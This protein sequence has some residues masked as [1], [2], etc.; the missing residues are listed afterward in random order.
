MITL[1][2]SQLDLLING[3]FKLNIDAQ[4]TALKTRLN[5]LLVT[6]NG[7]QFKWRRQYIQE[8]IN[9][10]DTLI[11]GKY[12]ELEKLIPVFDKIVHPTTIAHK[13]HKKFRDKLLKEMGYETNRG[14]FY[15]GF[16]KALGIKACVYCNSQLTVAVDAESYDKKK[17]LATAKI[18]AK[19]QI[20]HFTAKSEYPCFSVAY[21][22][23]YPVCGTCNN[24]KRTAS[25]KFRLFNEDDQVRNISA[26]SFAL[27]PGSE[28]NYL[29]NFDQA[30]IEFTFTDPEK[31]GVSYVPGSLTDTFDIVGIYETQKDV[32]EELIIKSQIYNDAYKQSLISKFPK[33]FNR[34][35]L[36][37]RVILGTYVDAEDIHKRPL[38]KFIQDIAKSLQ[39]I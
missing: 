28:A 14:E 10:S 26:Y 24:I 32:I 12:S 36:S 9:R 5:K 7:K 37:D 6:T 21:Y 3:Q 13:R 23:L 16:Y 25:V 18:K 29:M 8:I 2:G 15:P 34:S 39:K 22:N 30:K 33:L 38:A 31:P 1:H 27:K 4:E 20:D 17:K 35:D 11:R 19:F